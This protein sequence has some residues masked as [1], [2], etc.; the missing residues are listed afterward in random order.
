MMEV[1]IG[2]MIYGKFLLLKFIITV[3]IFMQSKLMKLIIAD[4][5]SVMLTY[6]HTHTHTH[7]HTQQTLIMLNLLVNIE[8]CSLYFC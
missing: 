6:I 8:K 1:K 7:T 5:I 2:K 3:G 4:I